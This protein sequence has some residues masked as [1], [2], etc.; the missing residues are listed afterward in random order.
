M[1]ERM[2]FQDP[3]LVLHDG[4]SE[5]GAEASCDASRGAVVHLLLQAIFQ[6]RDSDSSM[7]KG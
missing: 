3:C 4:W 5:A 1:G 6:T 7:Q 2:F